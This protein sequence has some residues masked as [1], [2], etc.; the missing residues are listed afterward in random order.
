MRLSDEC[1]KGGEKI[2]KKFGEGRSQ[3]AFMFS[4]F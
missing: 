4:Q 3:I 1:V 2:L